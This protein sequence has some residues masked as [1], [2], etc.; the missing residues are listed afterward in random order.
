MFVK[1]LVYNVKFTSSCDTFAN[2]CRRS[3]HLQH[4]YQHLENRNCE[5]CV[6]I[7][8]KQKHP[9]GLD[10]CYIQKNNMYI[11]YAQVASDTALSTT[12]MTFLQ[13]RSTMPRIASATMRISSSQ[14]CVSIKNHT[15]YQL[16]GILSKTVLSFC[17]KL[18]HT[19]G[20]ERIFSPTFSKKL[21]PNSCALNTICSTGSTSLYFYTT[22]MT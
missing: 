5:Q 16:M 19:V 20:I 2:C 14:K 13:N 7:F 10:G 22:I 1:T 3:Q 21:R 8:C 9:S 6:N 11:Q 15:L 17:I 12:L 18:F 4:F